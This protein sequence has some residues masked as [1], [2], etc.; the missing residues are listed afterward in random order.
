MTYFVSRVCAIGESLG[1]SWIAGKDM[2]VNL[3]S[4]IVIIP[5]PVTKSVD[6]R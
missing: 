2:Y 4:E 3:H 5:L 6:A 1:R